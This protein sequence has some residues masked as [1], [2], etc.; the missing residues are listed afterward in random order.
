MPTIGSL[1]VTEPGIAPKSHFCLQG[2]GDK[3]GWDGQA[4]EEILNTLNLNSTREKLQQN[5]GQYPGG[6][7]L[8]S[9]RGLCRTAEDFT[10]LL[11]WYKVQAIVFL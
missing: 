8:L 1:S 7:S 9:C 2:A 6:P 5:K 4:A 11:V 10:A 3:T